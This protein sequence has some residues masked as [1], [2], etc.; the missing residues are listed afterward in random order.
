[1]PERSEWLLAGGVAKR[2]PRYRD[3]QPLCE[4]R[5]YRLPRR[6][7]S[8]LSDAF[9]GGDDGFPGFAL[10][11][12]PRLRALGLRPRR[13]TFQVGYL[14]CHD[15]RRTSPAKPQHDLKGRMPEQNEWLLAGG[16]AKR[17]PRYRYIHHYAKNANITC[18]SGC[19]RF[20]LYFLQIM[21]RMFNFTDDYP[22][23]QFTCKKLLR[24]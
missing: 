1:M 17:N 10:T 9:L 8:R 19:F 12:N 5:E 14:R 21:V 24:L 4:E 16:G 3:A 11:L 6:L 22:T 23:N 2:N 13:S 20:L 18:S 15:D 7:L